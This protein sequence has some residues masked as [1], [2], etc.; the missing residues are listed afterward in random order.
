MLS[1]KNK[2]IPSKLV[3]CNGCGQSFR[4]DPQRN[5]GAAMQWLQQHEACAE[6]GSGSN[7]VTTLFS[8]VRTR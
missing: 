5:P 3:H 8:V 6:K 4:G 2:G 7:V 1:R